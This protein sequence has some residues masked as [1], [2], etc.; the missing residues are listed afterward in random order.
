MLCCQIFYNTFAMSI[1][2]VWFNLQKI[3]TLDFI[4]ILLRLFQSLGLMNKNIHAVSAFHVYLEKLYEIEKYKEFVYPDNYKLS[5]KLESNVAIEFE[6]VS[7][8]YLGSDFYLF[9]DLNLKFYKNKH[10]LVTGFNG[11]GKSTLLGLATG[12]FY[13]E[14]GKVFTHSNKI[15]YVSANPMI[16]NSSL[17]E[18]INYGNTDLV[19]DAV[20]TN[21]IK[22]FEVF[23]ENK[24]IDLEKLINNK[25]LSMGQM[26][27]ISFI[28]ALV[29]GIHILVLDESTSNLDTDSK[30]LIY[31]ILNKAELTIIN[32]THTPEGFFNFDHHIEIKEGN[33]GREIIIQ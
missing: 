7:F 17:R 27:K 3:V 14:Q 22:E 12:I 25:S 1:M 10:T 8:K 32:S 30:D 4:G 20:I 31:R 16:L 9:E 29:S 24:E 11:S 6:N 18:N 19:D 23:K 2:L 15:G 33:N 13:P 26:Q 5:D 21:Y 28:R